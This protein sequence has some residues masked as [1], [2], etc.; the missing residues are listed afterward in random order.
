MVAMGAP[1]NRN[2]YFPGWVASREWSADVDGP[3]VLGAAG[4]RWQGSRLR[5][6]SNE[7]A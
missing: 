3:G 2:R 6:D 5:K 1:L 7:S 4:A